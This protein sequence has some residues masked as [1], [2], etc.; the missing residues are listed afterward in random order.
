MR[1]HFCDIEGEFSYTCSYCGESFCS[2][3]RL[4]ENHAC[5][6]FDRGARVA[7]VTPSRRIDV[8]EPGEPGQPA[9]QASP[10]SARTATRNLVSFTRGEII[11]IA[12]AWLV[13]SIAYCFV[14]GGGYA[15]LF[16]PYDLLLMLPWTALAAILT[17]IIHELAHKFTAE[18]YG[19]ETHYKANN[20]MLLISLAISLTGFL[21]FMN[22]AV[23]IEGYP[24]RKQN[25][26]ISTAGPLTNITIAAITFVLVF[27][28]PWVMLI[29]YLFGMNAFIALFN[30]LP[31][32]NLDGGKI[33]RWSKV[34]FAIL[35][36]SAAALVVLNFL[37]IFS[38][39]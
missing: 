31:V 16:T 17:F 30:L 22:G 10:A 25:G 15:I 36:I 27:F 11:D 8:V 35:F 38:F 23:M 13:L 39:F 26:I 24:D 4:P 21:F 34:V 32:G 14:N 5:N 20:S 1:C 37:P 28:A 19:F 2:R 7:K 9:W 18:H 6:A 3:H 33:Y 29:K 12:K